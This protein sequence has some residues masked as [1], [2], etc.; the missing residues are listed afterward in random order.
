MK[1]R[2]IIRVCFFFSFDRRNLDYIWRLIQ[3]ILDRSPDL[4]IV[5]IELFHDIIRNRIIVNAIISFFFFKKKK[6][7]KW[8]D[9]FWK[10]VTTDTSILIRS[11]H[12]VNFSLKYDQEQ[13]IA[14]IKDNFSSLEISKSIVTQHNPFLIDTTKKYSFISSRRDRL[15][16]YSIE[17]KIDR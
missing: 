5:V 15:I 6:I 13:D 17:I 16:L 11:Y 12:S 7:M 3:N 9:K 2:V 14:Y 4:E 10:T 8:K 1:L